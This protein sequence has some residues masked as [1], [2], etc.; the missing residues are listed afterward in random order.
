MPDSA[1]PLEDDMLAHILITAAAVLV[2]AQ[3]FGAPD[4]ATP[5]VR[6][7]SGGIGATE[8]QVLDG[9]ARYNLKVVTA[10]RSGHFLADVDVTVVDDRGVKVLAA[11]MAGPWLL[12]ELPAGKYRVVAD[13]RGAT[14]TRDV[15]VGR[16]GRKEVVLHW[17]DGSMEGL[18]R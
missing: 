11:R 5:S 17:A 8:R 18:R 13:Y 4:G 6:M 2:G 12:A 14:Q 16:E 9:D 10:A 3:A 7:E 15:T 1:D